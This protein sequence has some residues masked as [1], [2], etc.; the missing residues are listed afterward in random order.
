[1]STLLDRLLEVAK[2]F[3]S[4]RMQEQMAH[5]KEIRALEADLQ[6][7][8]ESLNQR[9]DTIDAL[10]QAL[11][12]CQERL[13]EANEE[14]RKRRGGSERER[15]L[16][17][18]VVALR[19]RLAAAP[20]KKDEA[21]EIS[22]DLGAADKEN[23]QTATNVE[24]RNGKENFMESVSRCDFAA[25][26]SFL[27]PDCELEEEYTETMNTAL[28]AAC[29]IPSKEYASTKESESNGKDNS[30]NLEKSRKDVVSLVKFLIESGASAA[31]ARDSQGWSALERAASLGSADIVEILLEQPGVSV[32]ET[33]EAGS[34]RSALQLAV[35]C[36]QGDPAAVVRACLMA[37]ADPDF[38]GLVEDG[39]TARKAATEG[40]LARQDVKDV[41]NDSAVMF[42][43]ASMRAFDAYSKGN[44][45]RALDVYEEALNLVDASGLDLSNADRARLHYNRARASCH[46]GLRSEAVSELEKA[47][48]L[49]PDY[50]NAISLLSEC[51]VEL[52]QFEKAV[53][54]LKSLLQQDDNADGRGHGSAARKGGGSNRKKWERL[55]RESRRQ[56]DMNHYEILGVARSATEAE[57][58][59]AFRRQSIS[60][61][62]DK[63]QSSADSKSRANT[64][65]K[66][67][68]EAKQVLMDPYKKL[69]YDVEI[70]QK[71]PTHRESDSVSKGSR[72]QTSDYAS[73][74]SRPSRQQSSRGRHD[75]EARRA[76]SRERMEMQEDEIE[77]ALRREEQRQREYEREFEYARFGD[78]EAYMRKQESYRRFA[79]SQQRW[80]SAHD[81]AGSF[82]STILSDEELF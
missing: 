34:R 75:F 44:Y 73:E 29:G 24:G 3:E 37:G 18:E 61:H 52:L 51:F 2:E 17:R 49:V 50:K 7:M 8:T 1:M 63:H 59:K 21:M 16:Q 57:V 36:Q 4:D 43:N 58:K 23:L 30:E 82:D 68:N 65:F 25:I 38:K 69:M 19:F 79:D 6:D 41:F 66:R 5:K 80:E 20:K 62:P 54:L 47:I 35:T 76:R 39:V 53:P 27:D 26:T 56:R 33:A 67:V 13:Q 81:I 46:L 74:S 64:M 70:D 72:H 10:E 71:R 28:V 60:W 77:E 40:A 42:W 32:N 45:Q 14:L 12:D 48:E 9:Q 22:G 55:L 11:V 15:A 31:S 78:D